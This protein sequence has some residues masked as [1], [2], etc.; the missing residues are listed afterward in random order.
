LSASTSRRYC[1]NAGKAQSFVHQLTKGLPAL[2]TKTFGL[3]KDGTRDWT[4][5]LEIKR[6]FLVALES[7]YAVLKVVIR[8]KDWA[9]F[10]DDGQKCKIAA[11]TKRNARLPKWVQHPQ[12]V[13]QHLWPEALHVALVLRSG[14]DPLFQ[15]LLSI[16]SEL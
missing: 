14:H 2:K 3:L 11:Y 7:N 6:N 10:L 15:S 9:D 1:F 13:P 5:L 12:L 16:A 4:S 8:A